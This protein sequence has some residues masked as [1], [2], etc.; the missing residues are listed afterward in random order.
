[1]KL[2]KLAKKSDEEAK[3]T[4][5]AKDKKDLESVTDYVEEKTLDQ[6]KM[7]AAMGAM[8]KMKISEKKEDDR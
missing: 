2:A 4:E 1:L 3:R 7:N 8:A 5:M 6:D